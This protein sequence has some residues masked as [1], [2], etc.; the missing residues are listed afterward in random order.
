MFS[1][2][3]FT[4]I[5]GITPLLAIIFEPERS[6]QASGLFSPVGLSAQ[7]ASRSM[8]FGFSLDQGISSGLSY[9]PELGQTQLSL[10]YEAGLHFNFSK[11][12][13]AHLY[14]GYDLLPKQNIQD[15]KFG[16]TLSL[17]NFRGASLEYQDPHDF[18]IKLQY[19][20]DGVNRWGSFLRPW[21][22]EGLDHSLNQDSLSL[23][24]NKSFFNKALT[25][26]VQVIVP[27]TGLR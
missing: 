27:H 18:R 7:A 6:G 12:W 17:S 26:D 5:L 9:S 23:A 4:F 24:V 11:S 3:I 1:K 16:T 19:G 2:C 14:L 10:N 8:P 13:M 22:V 21:E 25:V 15:L 20:I